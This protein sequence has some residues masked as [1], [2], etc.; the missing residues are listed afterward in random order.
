M[1]IPAACHPQR[2]DNCAELKRD[3]L[4]VLEQT[5]VDGRVFGKVGSG[6]EEV[7]ALEERTLYM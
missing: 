1:A 3:P 4:G 2:G 5:N 6:P 7:C